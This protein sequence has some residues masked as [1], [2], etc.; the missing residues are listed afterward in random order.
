MRVRKHRLADVDQV[1]TS[2]NHACPSSLQAG[3]VGRW[4]SAYHLGAKTT[5]P[6]CRHALVVTHDSPGLEPS[7]YVKPGRDCHS[8]HGTRGQEWIERSLHHWMS[9]LGSKIFTNGGLESGMETLPHLLYIM[10]TIYRKQKNKE[11]SLHTPT[12]MKP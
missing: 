7:L 8:S 1:R 4:A 2:Q 12:T 11:G 6:R 9:K 10:K 3:S 5:I